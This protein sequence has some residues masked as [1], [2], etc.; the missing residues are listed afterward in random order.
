MTDVNITNIGTNRHHLPPDTMWGK[1]W[2]ITFVEVLPKMYLPNVII[3]EHQTNP[4]LGT[5]NKII[6]QHSVKSQERQRKAEE[7]LKV[8]EPNET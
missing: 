5:F 6:G 2:N 8:K 3:T 1:E 4:N 7:L